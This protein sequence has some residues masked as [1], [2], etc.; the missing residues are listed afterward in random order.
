MDWVLIATLF[1]LFVVNTV[2]QHRIGFKAGADGGYTV[3]VFHAVRWL[4]EQQAIA[5][6]DKQTGIPATDIELTRYI[7]QNSKYLH[8]NDATCRKLSE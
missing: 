3:G 4:M 7:I 1:V 2:L 8:M 5:A 6:E